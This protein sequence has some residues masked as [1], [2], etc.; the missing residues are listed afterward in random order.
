[1]TEATPRSPEGVDRTPAELAESLIHF[2]DDVTLI[3]ESVVEQLSDNPT[4]DAYLAW[5]RATLPTLAPDL[6]ALSEESDEKVAF[7]LARKLWNAMPVEAN[8]FEPLPMPDP[9]PGAP[10]PCE[11][12][13]SFGACCRDF[14]PEIPVLGES[15]WPAVAESRPSS[16]WLR[17]ARAGAL[18]DTGIMYIAQWFEEADEWQHVV[19]MLA[20]RVTGGGLQPDHCLHAMELLAI[21][22]RALE[23]TKD[24]NAMLRRFAAH[25]HASVRSVANRR[26]AMILHAEGHG[27]RAWRHFKAAADAAPDDPATAL[28]ELVLLTDEGRYP[29]AE[30]RAGDWRRHLLEAGVELDDPLLELVD[31]FARDAE[32]GRDEY[33]RWASPPAWCELLDWIEEAVDR[34]LPTPAWR[35]MQGSDDD[36]HLRGAHVPDVSAEMRRLETQWFNDLGA[37]DYIDTVAVA[38]RALWLREHDQ[39]LDSFVIM[40]ELAQFLDEHSHVLGGLENRWYGAVLERGADVLERSWPN[41]REGTLPW[42]LGDNR[43]ALGLLADYI[44]LLD[45]GDDRFEDLICLYL[46]LNP[47]DNHG[48]RTDLMNLLLV[49]GRDAEALELGERYP[50]DTFAETRYGVGLALYR[51]GRE[52]DAVD[53]LHSAVEHLPRVLQYLLRNRI[54]EPPADD[55]GM[56]IG[57]EYQAWRYREAMRETWLAVPGMYDW[58]KQFV[59]RGK[60]ALYG[61]RA[62]GRRRPR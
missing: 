52:A 48:Y 25:D 3:E 4:P 47:H 35:R 12:G 33:H 55:I 19:D 18:P 60:A 21:S 53:A 11:S 46:R 62:R 24:E 36:D 40:A 37:L 7:W 56:I 17:L 34:P 14:S 15:L 43:P 50:K 39:A 57:G 59:K 8:G 31:N 30:D 27:D 51:L 38:D 58:L 1:M 32:Y 29:E 20:P 61:K 9:E 28:Q 5:A 44:D 42:A 13:L 2:L 10:C 26:L 6:F 23:R 22:Y 54:K 41:D 16:H 45:D 49:A